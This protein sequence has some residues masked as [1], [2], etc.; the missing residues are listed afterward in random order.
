MHAASRCVL[1]ARRSADLRRVK[2]SAEAAT[3]GGCIC[4]HAQLQ[5]RPQPATS[6]VLRV[7]GGN[8]V[9]LE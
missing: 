4:R 5:R 7:G 8:A 6:E 1:A 3:A 9:D 2:P